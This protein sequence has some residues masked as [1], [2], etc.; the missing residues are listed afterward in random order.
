[1][2]PLL[3]FRD[4]KTFTIIQFTDVHWKNGD[5]HDAKSLRLMKDIVRAESPD[6]IVYTGDTIFSTDCSDPIASF[7]QATAVP[8]EAGIP[9]AA[10]FG[11]H[12]TEQGATREALMASLQSAKYSLSEGG[13]EA[14]SGV[15]N[16]VLSVQSAQG[17]F[18]S[19]ALK[20]YF[21]DS[22]DYAPEPI[23]GYGTPAGRL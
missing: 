16:Y 22:G 3:R 7:Q 11:N 21:F 17:S 12:D 8:E 14:L 9:W 2:K 5:E 23:G 10:V 20:L 4:D 1:M 18:P 6:L 19:E 15:G 13:P